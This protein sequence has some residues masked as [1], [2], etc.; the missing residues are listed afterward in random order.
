MSHNVPPPYAFV[1]PE[2]MY[3]RDSRT[4]I[5]GPYR[6]NTVTAP[7]SHETYEDRPKILGFHDPAEHPPVASWV[8]PGREHSAMLRDPAHYGYQV[9]HRVFAPN[10]PLKMG[11]NIQIV[12]PVTNL[13]YGD[14]KQIS[15]L[16]V[17]P[18]TMSENDPA[19]N[20]EQQGNLV[21]RCALDTVELSHADAQSRSLAVWITATLPYVI[22]SILLVRGLTLEGSLTGIKYYLT[23]HFASLLEVSV[24]KDAASQ[25]FFS[26]GP[27]FGVLLALSSYNKFHN[28]CYR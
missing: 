11:S 22:L 24:W 12:E 26:L 3:A 13:N 21:D 17:T 7:S 6:I 27:G 10:V 23:P 5:C 1:P 25:I 8:Q 9:N 18:M 4:M 15:T 19:V 20:A 2:Q 14:T 28:N 16:E